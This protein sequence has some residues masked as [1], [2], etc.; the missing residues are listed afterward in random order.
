MRERERRL[1]SKRVWPHLNQ[2]A[3]MHLNL[4]GVSH[5]KI[6]YCDLVWEANASILIPLEF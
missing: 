2:L 4:S 6:T 1:L 3:G 5:R